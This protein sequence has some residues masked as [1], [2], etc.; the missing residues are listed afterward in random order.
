MELYASTVIFERDGKLTIYDKTQ[1]VQNVQ[2]YVCSVF[3]M[4]SDDVRVMSP[5]VGGAFG[6]GLRPQFQVVLAALAARALKRSV[7]LLLTRQQMYGL[8]YRPAKLWPPSHLVDATAALKGRPAS[9]AMAAPESQSRI[10]PAE[11]V[12]AARDVGSWARRLRRQLGSI[13]VTIPL[14]LAGMIVTLFITRWDA[15]VGASTRQPTDDAYLRSDITPLS[16]KIEGYIH[17]VPANDFQQVKEGD[18]LVEIEDNDYG[19]RLAQAE[20]ELAGAEAAIANL[21]SR[22][23][24]QH[25]QIAEAQEAIDPTQADV[26]RTRGAATD[27]G[28][29]HRGRSTASGSQGEE[30]HGRSRQDRGRLYAHHR[31]DRRHGQ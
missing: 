26:E 2:R 9:E 1:G 12:P 7:R 13:P 5:F 16:A 11:P 28:A 29:R 27:G 15:W 30:G 3:D 18:L 6:S 22:K 19:A 8:G 21:K 31:A 25:S 24:L 17:R 4:K 23:A 10:A 14:L 20:A